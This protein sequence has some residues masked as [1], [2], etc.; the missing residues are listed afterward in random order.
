MSLLSNDP[1]TQLAFSIHENKGVFAILIGSGLSRAAEIPTGWEITVDL[2]RRVAAAQGVE[3]QPDWAKWYTDKTGQ[4]PNYSTLLED[5]AAS[6]DER[7]AILHRYIEPTEEDREQGR[8]VPT[9]AHRAIARL[10][11][12]GHIRVIITTNFDRL[13]ENALREL[14]IE[15]TVVSSVDSLL[16]A[17]PLTHTKCYLLKLHGDY[18]DARILNTDRELS[19]YP[20]EYNRLLDRIFDEHGL[21][22]CGWSGEWD[23]ALRA[24]FLRAPNRRYP[25]FW[26]ARGAMGN[27]AQELCAHR[28]AKVISIEGADGFFSSLQQRI[29]TLEQ[30]YRQNPLS[31]ELL[32]NTAKRYLSKPEYRIQ[33]DELFTAE[34]ERLLTQLDAAPLPAHTPWD[35]GEFRSRV[36]RYESLSEPLARMAGVLG[37]WGDGTELPLVIDIIDGLYRDAKK[38]GNGQTVWLNLRSYPAVL[39]F[40]AYGIGLTRAR[41][42]GTLHDLFVTPITREHRESKRL[43]D[44]LFL[45]MWEGG[46][47]DVWKQLEGFDRRKTPLSDHLVEVMSE[48]KTSFAG[49]SPDFELVCERFETLASLANLEQN[50]EAMLEEAAARNQE[51]MVW[52]PVGRIGWHSDSLHIVTSEFESEATVLALLH[53]GFARKSRRFLQLFIENLKRYAA[54]MRW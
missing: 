18:K 3:D 7:R 5:L 6:P 8:K 24:A 25:V 10:V 48:W 44:T 23:H 20:N 34:T 39:V 43:V 45:G 15:P 4:E 11:Q 49:V 17:E 41:R 29:E 31:V 35:Q 13:M 52:M 40:T 53:A 32:V 47:S 51:I 50:D 37:R 19:A 42:W 33:L 16:G 26:A 28:Q 12:S 14:G 36:R 27:G 21:I 1:L 30:S 54:R 2:V 22:I 9:K 46:Q 38:I